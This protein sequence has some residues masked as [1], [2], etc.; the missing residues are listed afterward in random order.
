MSNKSRNGIKLRGKRLMEIDS[1]SL[2][3]EF[4]DSLRWEDKDSEKE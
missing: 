2:F 4:V 1:D 3:V